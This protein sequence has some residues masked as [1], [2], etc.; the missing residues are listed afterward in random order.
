M[1][2]TNLYSHSAFKY[3]LVGLGLILGALI[4][5]VL[6]KQHSDSISITVGFLILC[7]GMTAILGF[8]KSLRGLKEPNTIKK[9]VGLITNTVIVSLFVFTV[10]AN[11][12]DVLRVLN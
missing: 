12:V 5:I 7:G 9:I 11:I 2:K 6:G 10:I 1:T 3:G 4:L 8:A